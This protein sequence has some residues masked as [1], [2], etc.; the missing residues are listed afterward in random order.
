[1]LG[2]EV[3]IY[4]SQNLTICI[5]QTFLKISQSE[6]TDA[7]DLIHTQTPLMYYGVSENLVKHCSK[8]CLCMC[9]VRGILLFFKNLAKRGKRHLELKFFETE[10][11]QMLFSQNFAPLPPPN[12]PPHWNRNCIRFPKIYSNVLKS[13]CETVRTILN[14]NFPNFSK[15]I[16]SK[17]K[18][19]P[20][21]IFF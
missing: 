8:G 21:K 14:E 3:I 16:F 13:L 7:P 11:F 6:V 17:K 19:Y 20:K 2:S 9:G 18:F 1:M 4:F 10:I 5:T 15:K 12:P